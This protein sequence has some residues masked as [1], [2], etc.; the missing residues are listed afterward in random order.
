MEGLRKLNVS[1]KL[2]NGSL[3]DLYTK[4]KYKG[5]FDIVVF[6]LKTDSVMQPEFNVLLN[7][8][9]TIFCECADTC[10]IV[11]DDKRTEY[12]SKLR[13]KGESAGWTFQSGPYDHYMR[14]TF[15]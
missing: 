5:L 4:S 11:K 14:F 9:A 2:L 1:F 8:G 15:Q 7:S 3:T 10:V 13:E 12:K 6:S